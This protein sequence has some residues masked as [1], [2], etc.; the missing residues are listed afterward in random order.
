MLIINEK[1]YNQIIEFICTY[2]GIT[3]GELYSILK[4]KDSRYLLFLI[5]KKYSCT[6]KELILKILK[7]KSKNTVN[8]SFRKAEEKFFV[9][10]EFRERY[11]KIE[12]KIK[13]II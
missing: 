5:L 13:E 11:F 12:E 9:N 8:S 4:D 2:N 6:D 7:L 1:L 10:K 3:K